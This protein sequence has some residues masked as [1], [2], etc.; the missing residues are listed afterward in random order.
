M[1][2]IKEF[3][4][5]SLFFTSP[6]FYMN[7]GPK[8]K[9][10]EVKGEDED[11]GRKVWQFISP[12]KYQMEIT[13]D[14]LSITSDYHKSY[15]NPSSDTRFRDIIDFVLKPFFEITKIPVIKRVGLRYIDHCP[16]K[17]KDNKTFKKYYDSTFPLDKFDISDAEL[18]HFRILTK[19]NGFSL[20]YMETLQPVE[21]EYK[22]IMDFD[23]FSVNI[24]SE[25]ILS[26][27]DNL[28][29]LISV[30]YHSRIKRPLLHYMKTKELK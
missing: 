14:S 30:E 9:F 15:N 6:S 5:S 16:I 3:P 17:S 2:I 24:N 19:K 18:M 28:H 8:G 10:E 21:D 22:L 7:I 23:G 1:R 11:Q 26:V 27:T 25:E 4:E 20:N 12:K 13:S 29:D